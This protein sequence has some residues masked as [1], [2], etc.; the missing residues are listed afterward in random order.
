MIEQTTDVPTSYTQLDFTDIH[1]VWTRTIFI[2][3]FVLVKHLSIIN[4][5]I[6]DY[7]G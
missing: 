3:P 1:D 4:K 6:Q 2:Q 5:L 7:I